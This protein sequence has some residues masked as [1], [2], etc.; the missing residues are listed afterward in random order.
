MNNSLILLNTASCL[1]I[2]YINNYQPFALIACSARE[3]LT[4]SAKF[5]APTGIDYHFFI[6]L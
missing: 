3:L 1:N 5:T 4:V 6:N 2:I